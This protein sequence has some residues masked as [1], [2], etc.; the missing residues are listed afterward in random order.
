MQC[1]HEFVI[2]IDLSPAAPVN[3]SESD[4]TASPH[5]PQVQLNSARSRERLSNPD[6]ANTPP[7][8]S[9]SPAQRTSPRPESQ[10]TTTSQEEEEASEHSPT[11][12]QSPRPVVTPSQFVEPELLY[13][14]CKYLRSVIKPLLC[15]PRSIIA[16]GNHTPPV[17][18]IQF[19]GGLPNV[20][21]L[22]YGKG[23]PMYIRASSWRQLLKLLAKLS[24]CQI[25][26]TVEARAET[27]GAL[28]LQTVIQFFRVCRFDSMRLPRA[29]LISG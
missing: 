2:V 26:P 14:A 8:N 19:R 9:P 15:L 17:E 23:Q 7:R 18:N 21:A 29:I 11:S 4:A 10:T 5:V 1:N 20:L 22:P 12:P 13:G 6:Q 27:K 25:E 16:F 3:R 28:L 24:A